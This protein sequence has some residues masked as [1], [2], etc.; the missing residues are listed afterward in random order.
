MILCPRRYCPGGV[1]DVRPADLRD[2]GIEAVL[3]DLDNTL[4]A[5]QGYDVP[6]AVMEWL[7]ELRACGLKLYLVSNTRS[8]RRLRQLAAE[9]E[10]SYVRRAWK[11]RR[12]GFLAAMR[13]LGVGPDRT[14]VIGDQMFTDVLGGNRLGLYTVMVR[15]MA[16]REFVGTRL[17][18]LAER[19]VLAWLRR[20]GLLP[21]GG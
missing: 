17:S 9:L 5:W 20:R 15:P 11:P 13:E 18:R 2:A 8:G 10:M 4:V 1:T 19:V 6:D 7:A 16:R 3:L 14:A 21:E 12:R